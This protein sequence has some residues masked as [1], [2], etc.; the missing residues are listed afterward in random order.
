M[1][2]YMFKLSLSEASIRKPNTYPKPSDS[3]LLVDFPHVDNL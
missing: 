1:R 3:K 2:A